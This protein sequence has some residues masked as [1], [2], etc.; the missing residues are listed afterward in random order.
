MDITYIQMKRAFVYQAVVKDCYS[1]RTLSH[2]LSIT[3]DTDFC[4]DALEDAITK[5]SKPEIMN[6]DHGSQFTSQ[7]FTQYLKGSSIRISM[8]GSG[9]LRDYVF[10]ERL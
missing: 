2:R 10:V 5:Y 3:M 7:T 8:D 1:R 6:T 9:A 4:L